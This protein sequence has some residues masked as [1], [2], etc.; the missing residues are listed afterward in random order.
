MNGHFC[1]GRDQ[2]AQSRDRTQN[3]RQ[4]FAAAE[5]IL[6]GA[7]MCHLHVPRALAVKLTQNDC[8]VSIAGKL[9]DNLMAPPIFP[10]T[11]SAGFYSGRCVSIERPTSLVE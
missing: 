3:F 5:Q 1:F 9:P 11:I 6:A 7:S 8:R 4:K 2:R 10:R